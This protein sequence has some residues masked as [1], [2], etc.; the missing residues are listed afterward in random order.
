MGGWVVG[1]ARS[2][3]RAWVGG[4]VLVYRETKSQTAVCWVQSPYFD[5]THFHACESRYRPRTRRGPPKSQVQTTKGQ[6]PTSHV[7]GKQVVRSR[8]QKG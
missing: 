6:D 7:L 5:V 2:C 8:A 4:R 1:S 3:G